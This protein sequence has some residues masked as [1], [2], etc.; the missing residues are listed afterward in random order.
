MFQNLLI[1]TEET[2]I[3]ALLAM[4]LDQNFERAGACDSE[5][6]QRWQN[7]VSNAA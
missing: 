2:S 3:N 7:I 6:K 4:A 1:G 5:V